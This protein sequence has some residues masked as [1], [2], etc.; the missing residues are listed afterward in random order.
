MRRRAR[1]IVAPADAGAAGAERRRI[2]AAPGH[3]KADVPELTIRPPRLGFGPLTPLEEE[4]VRCMSRDQR[5]AAMCAGRLTYGQLC[6]WASRWPHEVPL[7][8]NEFA[9]IAYFEAEAAESDAR[10]EVSE[11]VAAL[12]R[13]A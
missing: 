6:W 3:R 1:L 8:N 11:Q 10:V 7:I 9:F 4:Q 12:A 5:I 13:V 2:R